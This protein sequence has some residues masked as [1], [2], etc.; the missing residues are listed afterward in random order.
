MKQLMGTA[1]PFLRFPPQL[2]IQ[3]ELHPLT[4]APVING[5]AGNRDVQHLLQTERLRAK[6]NGIAVIK[7]RAPDFVLDGIRS[8]GG[9]EFYQVSASAQT[10]FC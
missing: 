3:F 7:L 10:V 2:R 5:S 1:N 8:P 4:C 6:L 9:V